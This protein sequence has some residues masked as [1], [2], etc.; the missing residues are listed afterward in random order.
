LETAPKLA[1]QNGHAGFPTKYPDLI[2]PCKDPNAMS[3]SGQGDLIP[4]V[5]IQNTRKQDFICDDPEILRAFQVLGYPVHP[6]L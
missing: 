4:P 5:H 6:L 2:H 3:K 1:N